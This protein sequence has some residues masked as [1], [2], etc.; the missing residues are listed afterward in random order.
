M[1][2]CDGSKEGT[3]KTGNH[4]PPV[5]GKGGFSS[6]LLALKEKAPLKTHT[7]KVRNY[8]GNFPEGDQW[9]L[10]SEN[11]GWWLAMETA[12]EG[13]QWKKVKLGS[14]IMR[15]GKAN[16]MLAWNGERMDKGGDHAAL[17]ETYPEMEEW[18]VSVL[19]SCHVG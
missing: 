2:V 14:K 4:A 3:V 11:A 13:E 9:K 15:L 5:G 16:F 10:V 6:K 18:A 7:G 19:G 12:K 17:M 8:V 1:R